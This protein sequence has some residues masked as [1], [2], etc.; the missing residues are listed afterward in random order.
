MGSVEIQ[1]HALLNVRYSTSQSRA[2]F[3]FHVGSR[4]A[5]P[6]AVVSSKDRRSHP[7]RRTSGN[8]SQPRLQR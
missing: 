8:V 1:V 3:Y 5:H 2:V 6:R 4:N 7:R